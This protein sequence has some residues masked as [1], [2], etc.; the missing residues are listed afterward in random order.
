MLRHNLNVMH[1]EKNVCDNIIYTLLYKDGRSKDG[2]KAR[3]DMQK[4]KNRKA[5]HP[6][7]LKK[8]AGTFTLPH[9]SYNMTNEEKEI[10]LKVLKDYETSFWV[11]FKSFKTSSIPRT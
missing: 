8:K 3:L 1:I 11:L 2:L 9:A 5:L 4:M 6:R 7:P 10:F